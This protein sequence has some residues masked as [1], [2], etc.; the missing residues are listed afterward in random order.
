MSRVSPMPCHEQLCKNSE[1]YFWR[2][3]RV[4]HTATRLINLGQ[5]DFATTSNATLPMNKMYISLFTCHTI[6]F[7]SI[8]KP[9]Q[10][11]PQILVDLMKQH[12]IRYIRFSIIKKFPK[13]VWERVIRNRQ[14]DSIYKIS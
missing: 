14:N 6:K 8:Q 12:Q 4:C 13:C 11:S 2:Y 7:P 5:I 9:F 10:N 1:S 3:T